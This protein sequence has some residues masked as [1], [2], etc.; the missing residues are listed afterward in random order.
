MKCPAFEELSPVAIMRL[1]VRGKIVTRT[2][3]V[4][5]AKAQRFKSPIEKGK[6]YMYICVHSFT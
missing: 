2:A 5:Y 1:M 4:I 3:S 6:I